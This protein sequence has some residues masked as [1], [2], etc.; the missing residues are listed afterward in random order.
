MTAVPQTGTPK[1]GK[2]TQ[3]GSRLSV[4]DATRTLALPQ[5]P[6]AD[7]V[8]AALDAVA[9]PPEVIEVGVRANR[10]TAPELFARCVWPVGSP[11][12]DDE[13]RAAGLTLAWSHVTG[14]TAHTAYDEAETLAVDVLAPPAVLAHAA[15]H[16]AE[17]G[18]HR[19]WQPPAGPARWSEAVYLDVALGLFDEKDGP[20]W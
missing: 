6:Y 19:P 18:L 12:L 17:Y 15:L 3:D 16:M 9:M 4:G 7:A 20:L 14:W 2:S 5:V 11:L 13:A 1:V 10:P 8:H